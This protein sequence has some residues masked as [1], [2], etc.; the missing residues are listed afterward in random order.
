LSS[1]ILYFAI[2]AIWAGVLI[3]RWLRRDTSQA[4]SGRASDSAEFEQPVAKE[5][6]G[7]MDS[8]D[9]GPGSP[10]TAGD[11]YA[12]RN[13]GADYEPE[14]AVP[15]L[16]ADPAS[17]ARVLLARRR[18][19]MMLAGLTV[20]AFGIVTVRL[21]AW[22]V[23]ITPTGMLVGY[24][25]LLREARHVDA[26]RALIRDQAMTEAEEQRQ[27]AREQELTPAVPHEEPRAAQIID[28]SDRVR[29]ELYD[30]YAD[31]ERRAVGD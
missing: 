14:E 9:A 20:A 2:I 26:E 18:M 4:G 30:Q 21:A 3:P 24:L 19:L 5:A 13:E 1:A 11:S 15:Y 28:I 16:A 8:E 17:R 6:P 10:G 25:M 7:D 27:V 31:T 12:D 29:D 23:T 22:W